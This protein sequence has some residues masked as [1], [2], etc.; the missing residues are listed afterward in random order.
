MNRIDN[1]VY[2]ENKFFYFYKTVYSFFFFSLIR[3]VCLINK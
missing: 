3:Y 2:K 1:K